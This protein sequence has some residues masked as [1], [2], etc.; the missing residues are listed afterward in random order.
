MATPR[1]GDDQARA[2]PAGPVAASRPRL[3]LRLRTVFI[4]VSL[5]VLILPIGG[6][7]VMRIHE[8]T[9]LR[10]T[11]S[12]LAALAAFVSASYRAAFDNALGGGDLAAH[13]RAADPLI[14][15]S[16]APVLDISEAAVRPPLPDAPPAVPDS[17]ARRIGADL[18]PVLVDAKLVAGAGI[19]LVDHQGVVVATTEGDLGG[20]LA[21]V[22][23]V[24]QALR[25]V[26]VSGLRAVKRVAYIAPVVRGAAIQVLVARPIVSAGRI[27][28]AVVLMHQPTTILGTLYR[29]RWLLLQVTALILAVTVGIGLVTARTLVLPIKRLANG[30]RRLARGE[31]N[32]FERGRHYRVQ[33][34]A[35]LANNIETL[36][37]SLQQR[38]DYIRDFVRHV[39]HEFK[40]PLAALGGALEVLRDHLQDMSPAEGRHFVNNMTADLERLNRLTLRLLELAQADMVAASDEIT[41]VLEVARGL[42]NPAVRVANGV[43]QPARIPRT[44][45]RAVLENLVDNAAQHGAARVE[46]RAESDARGVALWVADDGPGIA[47]GNRANIFEPFFTTR[48]DSGGTGLGL[49]ICRSLVNNAGGGIELAASDHG[50]AF[51]ITLPRP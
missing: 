18:T 48:R 10:E 13:S 39:S 34:L 31:T 22:E 45:I 37:T 46:V 8:S 23:E 2:Q 21:H 40:T 43:S 15:A 12:K 47:P 29:E 17:L 19:R 5:L 11:E 30:A 28:G 27:L 33:E 16:L 4:V 7:Y 32:T 1:V 20:S 38:A 3:R 35:E 36:A 26:T 14:S 50:A 44:S 25:G 41:D 9:L 49:A 51:K 42:D 24:G 6:L